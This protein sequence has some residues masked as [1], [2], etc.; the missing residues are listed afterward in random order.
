MK[1]LWKGHKNLLENE[2][3]ILNLKNKVHICSL[4]VELKQNSRKR[5]KFF[6]VWSII[7]GK[8]ENKL[9]IN[10]KEMY[11]LGTEVETLEIGEKQ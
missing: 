6:L 1:L 7:K 2:Y 8:S 5:F 11:V 4:K 3:A 9:K 10:K